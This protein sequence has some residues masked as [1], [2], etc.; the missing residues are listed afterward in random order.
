MVHSRETICLLLH[1]CPCYAR[2]MMPVN[3][4]TGMSGQWSWMIITHYERINYE[5]WFVIQS[6][7]SLWYYDMIRHYTLLAHNEGIPSVT[8]GFPS[9]RDIIFYVDFFPVLLVSK[10]IAQTVQLM[11]IWDAFRLVLRQGIY[12]ALSWCLNDI[13]FTTFIKYT[14]IT[15]KSLI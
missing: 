4:L 11:E 5:I 13:R 12:L 2:Q 9:Q 10:A 15:V 3:I 8:G 7:E 14:D 1:N 6:A